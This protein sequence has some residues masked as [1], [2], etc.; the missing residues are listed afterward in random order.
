MTSSASSIRT[1]VSGGDSADRRNGELQFVSRTTE[2]GLGK[3]SFKHDSTSTERSLK[4]SVDSNEVLINNK[5]YV[6]IGSTNPESS[7]TIKGN[8]NNYKESNYPYRLT[9]LSLNAN[10]E[11]D[12]Y[13]YSTDA[14]AISDTNFAGNTQLTIE[15]WFVHLPGCF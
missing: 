14:T 15:I 4:F 9:S 5:G 12:Q 1:I 11:T 10:G 6:G 7:L 3:V 2:Q 8:I 13:A